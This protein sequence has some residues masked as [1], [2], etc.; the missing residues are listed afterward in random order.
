MLQHSIKQ[1]FPSFSQSHIEQK[2][3]DITSTQ[4]H[5]AHVALV[6]T[7]AAYFLTQ[8]LVHVSLLKYTLSK[9]VAT[10]KDKPH[11]L[12]VLFLMSKLQPK[13]LSAILAFLRPCWLFGAC[14]FTIFS[15][16]SNFMDS[17]C[18]DR[19]GRGPRTFVTASLCAQPLAALAAEPSFALG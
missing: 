15:K 19:A 8:W 17:N 11:R 1:I 14:F 7:I 9:F 5:G 13:T 6:K 16:P 2:H 4:L 18:M 3:I 12:I 10:K